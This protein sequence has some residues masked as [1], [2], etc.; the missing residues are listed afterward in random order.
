MKRHQDGVTLIETLVSALITAV[1]L[2]GV[3]ELHSTAKRSSFGSLQYVHAHALVTDIVERMRANP[4]QLSVYASREYGMGRFNAPATLC[5]ATN[6]DVP[7]CTPQEIAEWDRY[8]WDQMLTGRDEKVGDRS[9]GGA[10]AMQ[11]CITVLDTSVEVVV[12]WLT[13]EDTTDGAVSGT[14]AQCGQPDTRRR[15]V[16]VET[17]VVEGI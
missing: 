15:S 4:A 6:S 5:G 12:V 11:G 1:G 17:A 13:L 9:V 16:R 2:L 7:A 8:S 14:A 3:F 10:N